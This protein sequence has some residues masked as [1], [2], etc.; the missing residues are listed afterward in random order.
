[1][2][3]RY[4]HRVFDFMHKLHAMLSLVMSKDWMEAWEKQQFNME[5]SLSHGPCFQTMHI[6]NQLYMVAEG[7]KVVSIVLCQQSIY[8]AGLL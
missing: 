4:M 5:P 8:S 3:H 6:V 2:S 7:A 1:M